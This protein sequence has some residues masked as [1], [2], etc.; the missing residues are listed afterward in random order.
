MRSCV[1][2]KLR[3]EVSTLHSVRENEREVDRIIRGILKR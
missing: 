3:K 2:K 1:A